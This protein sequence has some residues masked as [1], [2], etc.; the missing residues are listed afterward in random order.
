MLRQDSEAGLYKYERVKTFIRGM[1]YHKPSPSHTQ[2]PLY[3]DELLEKAWRAIQEL[4]QAGKP[5]THQAVC[6]L[7]GI[8]SKTFFRHPKVK[9]LVGRFVDYDLQQQTY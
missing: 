8:S 6:S 9:K 4:T 5:I 3:E 1:L 2:D 7:I